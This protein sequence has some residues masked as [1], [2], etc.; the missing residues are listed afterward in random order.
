MSE[1]DLPAV[2]RGAPA[3]VRVLAYPDRVFDGKVEWVSSTLDP[4]LRTA[5][6]RCTL[7]NPDGLLKP[8]MFATVV[9][10][11]P[12]VKGLAIPR[13][14]VVQI[15]DHPFVHVAAGSRAGW[16][17]GLRAPPGPDTGAVGTANEAALQPAWRSRLPSPKWSPSWLVWPRARRS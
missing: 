15:N 10:E 1:A 7:P 2:E 17:A 3:E 12:A 13:E 4:A 16:E 11:R 9:I 6:V 14:A 8:E 5:R